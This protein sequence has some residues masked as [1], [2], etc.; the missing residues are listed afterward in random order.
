MWTFTGSKQQFCD[1]V[2]RRNFLQVGALGLGGLTLPKLLRAESLASSQSTRKSIINIYLPGGPSHMDMFDLKPLAPKEFR[3][4]FSPIATNVDG[5]EICEHMPRLAKVA[6]KFSVI[7]SLTG[8]REEH[9]SYQSDSGWSDSSLR[10]MGGRPGVGCVMTKLWGPQQMTPLGGCPTFVDLTGW[11]HT[12][13]LGQVCAASAPTT[14][15]AATSRSMVRF[16]RRGWAT[17][18]LCSA[19]WTGSNGTSTAAA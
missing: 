9:S 6:D 2:S 15:A 16:R 19:A 14:K 3:G 10:E 11:T 12:G 8:I 5:M 17:G 7:R 1:G 4:E 13:F 18:N